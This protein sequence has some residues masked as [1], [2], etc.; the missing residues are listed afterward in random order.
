VYALFKGWGRGIHGLPEKDILYG[1]RCCFSAPCPLRISP[2][3][4]HQVPTV[5]IPI[6]C[7]ENTGNGQGFNTLS[8]VGSSIMTGATFAE[9]QAGGVIVI[10]GTLL[11][12]Y[13]LAEELASTA[14]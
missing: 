2:V 12:I 10:K 4:L 7:H 8:S 11:M 5:S 3:L 13:R 14:P 1:V 9:H 6:A